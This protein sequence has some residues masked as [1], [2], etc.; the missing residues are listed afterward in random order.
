V[1]RQ[2][3]A[4]AV[5][6]PSG[7]RLMSNIVIVYRGY[8]HT[9]KLAEAVH[10]GADAG[11]T[12]RLIAVGELDDAGWAALDAADAIV[13]GAPTYMGGPSASSNSLQMR[14][15]NRGSRRNGRTSSPPASRTR[16]R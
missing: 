14:R 10:A 9:Q 1:T 3:A 8:G 12:A 11:A 16:R 13:F 6:S 7:E 15:R 2:A 5:S 4:A